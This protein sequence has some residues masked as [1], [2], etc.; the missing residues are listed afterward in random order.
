VLVMTGAGALAGYLWHNAEPSSILMG[1]AGSR[2]LGLL[3]GVAVLATG[4]PLL[5]LVVAPVVLVNGGTGLVK[6]VA[7]RMFRECGFDIRPPTSREEGTGRP[8]DSCA[9]SASQFFVVRI[10][11]RLQFPLH[12]HCRRNL[13]WTNAQ[14]LLRFVLLQAMLI[15]LLLGLMVKIR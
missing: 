8:A 1:D 7:L 4:N 10:L 5:V 14:V 15:P 9:H 3:V 6:I 2:F 12:D 11:H 13:K